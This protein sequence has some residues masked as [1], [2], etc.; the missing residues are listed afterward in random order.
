M[1]KLT[2]KEVVKEYNELWASMD[3]DTMTTARKWAES[4]S[5][6]QLL[7]AITGRTM[8]YGRSFKDSLINAQLKMENRER[9]ISFFL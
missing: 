5:D 4:L 6:R 9:A 2:R 8:L 3:N 7:V 1:I